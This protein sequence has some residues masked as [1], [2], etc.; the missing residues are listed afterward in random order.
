MVTGLQDIKVA[1]FPIEI[2]RTL[3]IQG[4]KRSEN[5][6]PWDR[7]HDSKIL[8]VNIVLS[9]GTTTKNK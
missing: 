9:K 6:R 2:E 1:P 7:K 4:T 3:Y 8:G 5:N